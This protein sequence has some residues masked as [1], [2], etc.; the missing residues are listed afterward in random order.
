MCGHLWPL[1]LPRGNLGQD[2][3]HFQSPQGLPPNSCHSA[4]S[5][6]L[7]TVFGP[8][9]SPAIQ[10]GSVCPIDGEA[11]Q[12]SPGW[13]CGRTR[14][15]GGLPADPQGWSGQVSSGPRE[16][17]TPRGPKHERHLSPCMLWEPGPSAACVVE[18]PAGGLAYPPNAQSTDLT[19]GVL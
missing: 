16:G 13:R 4:A 10:R 3:Q 11:G 18:P 15:Q 1:A 19:P 7:R 17:F 5:T 2:P 9:T 6:D 14:S 12:V 8:H